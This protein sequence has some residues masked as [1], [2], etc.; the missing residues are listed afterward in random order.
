MFDTIKGWFSSAQESAE[1]KWDANTL[2]VQQP[3]SPAAPAMNQTVSEQPGAP[4]SMV[5][6]G[7]HLRG[8]GEGDICCGM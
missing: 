8:G 5:T 2:T 6:D 1:G 4:E 7:V 3:T